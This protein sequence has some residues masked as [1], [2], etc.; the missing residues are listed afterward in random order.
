MIGE[1]IQK[2]IRKTC[3][4]ALEK[5][6]AM[7]ERKGKNVPYLHTPNERKFESVRSIA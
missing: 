6:A 5:Q 3:K 4:S 2:S 1:V 7:Q